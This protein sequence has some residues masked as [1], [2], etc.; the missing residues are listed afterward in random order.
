MLVAGLFA[1][2]AAAVGGA[3]AYYNHRKA[4]KKEAEKKENEFEFEVENEEEKSK[5]DIDIQNVY[6][7]PTGPG[8]GSNQVLK[9]DPN[10]ED[11]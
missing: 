1:L 6:L 7:T 2:G 11:P 5:E 8:T 4:T 10:F 3:V 9:K